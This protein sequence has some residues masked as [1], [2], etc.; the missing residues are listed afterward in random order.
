[1]TPTHL[2]LAGL[3]LPDPK[4]LDERRHAVVRQP[5]AQHVPLGC[6]RLAHQEVLQDNTTDH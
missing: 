6:A 1:M 3:L 4:L 5:D 2:T